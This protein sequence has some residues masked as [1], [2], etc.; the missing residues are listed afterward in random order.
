MLTRSSARTS[1]SCCGGHGGWH[2]GWIG[3]D[4]A[5]ELET[6]AVEEMLSSSSASRDDGAIDTGSDE[7][8]AEDSLGER[9]ASS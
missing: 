7:R 3:A 9:G 2:G 6:S 8:P 4:M 1:S 5:E